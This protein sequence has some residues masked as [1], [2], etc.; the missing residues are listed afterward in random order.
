MRFTT[1]L[2]Y[3]TIGSTPHTTLLPSNSLE[4]LL[5]L[6][7]QSMW[8]GHRFLPRFISRH[9]IVLHERLLSRYDADDLHERHI[10]FL[11]LFHCLVLS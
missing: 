5:L 3:E 7:L 8:H 11:S 9:I 10:S 1:M 6:L 4:P 2:H